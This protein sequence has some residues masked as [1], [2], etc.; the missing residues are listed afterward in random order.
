MSNNESLRDILEMQEPI[1]PFSGTEKYKLWSAIQH[2]TS[3]GKNSYHRLYAP[4][5]THSHYDRSITIRD[6]TDLALDVTDDDVLSYDNDHQ[7]IHVPNVGYDHTHYIAEQLTQAIFGHRTSEVGHNKEH[8]KVI[9][10]Y[11][12]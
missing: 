9:K 12:L 4:A 8:S 5:K 7:G 2:R 3:S 1:E 6:V 11:F 10:V